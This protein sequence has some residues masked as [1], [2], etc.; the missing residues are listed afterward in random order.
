MIW[1]SDPKTLSKRKTSKNSEKWYGLPWMHRRE[2]RGN[3]EPPIASSSNTL[4]STSTTIHRRGGILPIVLMF[5]LVLRR[6]TD[7]LSKHDPCEQSSLSYPPNQSDRCTFLPDTELSSSYTQYQH[8]PLWI[9]C[10]TDSCMAFGT[11]RFLHYYAPRTCLSFSL[12]ER[13]VHGT[14]GFN[15]RNA[16]FI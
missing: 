12:V 3:E 13:S 7:I 8:W 11:S 1:P 16:L 9:I 10:V 4:K 15:M 14:T 6:E 2:R 5:N